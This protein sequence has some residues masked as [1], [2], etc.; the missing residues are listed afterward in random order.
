[1][2]ISNLY[3]LNYEGKEGEKST[4]S[5]Y[6]AKLRTIYKLLFDVPIDGSIIDELDK[7]LNGKTIN[8]GI[9][10]HIQFFKNIIKIE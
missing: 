6:L 2:K 3:T 4:N 7:L 8:Q 5:P 9:I 1:M 10:N